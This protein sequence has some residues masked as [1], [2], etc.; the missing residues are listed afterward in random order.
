VW[1]DSFFEKLPK[2][3][4]SHL[5]LIR[6]TPWQGSSQNVYLRSLARFWANYHFYVA[7]PPIWSSC[8]KLSSKLFAKKSARIMRS[9]SFF[10]IRAVSSFTIFWSYFYWFFSILKLFSVE[11]QMTARQSTDLSMVGIKLCTCI[12]ITNWT[13]LITYLKLYWLS[14]NSWGGPDDREFESRRDLSFFI[15]NTYIGMFCFY[16]LMRIFTECLRKLN[17]KTYFCPSSSFQADISNPVWTVALCQGC[18]MAYFQTE[19]LVW[20]IF[21][22]SC[23]GRCWSIFRPF[24]LFHG[25]LVHVCGHLVYFMVILVYF[26]V[27][28]YT[29]IFH[30][31]ILYQG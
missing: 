9:T 6:Q 29:Y 23:N 5:Y 2:I 11:I 18:Q 28:W 3:P 31:G 7:T 13:M 8:L 20:I 27:D 16:S 19:I 22:G 15:F 4:I 25:H 14:S 12:A 30:F 24:V 10:A 1:F 21:G 17:V 26:M